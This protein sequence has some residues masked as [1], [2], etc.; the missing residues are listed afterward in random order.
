M[1]TASMLDRSRSI[2]DV[3]FLCVQPNGSVPETVTLK[4]FQLPHRFYNA[5]FFFFSL[6]CSCPQYAAH[7]HT[8]CELD[9]SSFFTETLILTFIFSQIFK[10]QRI[11]DHQQWS[12]KSFE[13]Q[14]NFGPLFRLHILVCF[15]SLLVHLQVSFKPFQAPFWLQ[16]L[17]IFRTFWGHF[18][19]LFGDNFQSVLGHI[20]RNNFQSV[21]GH[22][23][24]K[25]FLVSFSTF[26]VIFR[27]LFLN[28]L[29]SLQA[30]FGGQFLVSFRT[31]FQIQFFSQLQGTFLG[32]FGP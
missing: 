16:F 6:T 8:V 14:N 31:L 26:S 13:K 24:Y 22:F 11:F 23:F 2:L 7:T 4:L 30:T 28:I 20:F 29:G 12:N 25:Q 9:K 3:I 21:L 17:V 1:L 15:R 5:L 10:L 27:P 32:H 19:P 18:R